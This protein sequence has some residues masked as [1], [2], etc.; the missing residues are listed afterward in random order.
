M[1]RATT[2]TARAAIEL[3]PG[4][5]VTCTF[6]NTKQGSLTVVK[7]DGGWRRRVRLQQPDAVADELQPD[8]ERRDGAAELRQSCAGR[9]RCERDCASGLGP[10]ERDLLATAVT[11]DSVLVGAGENVTCTFVNTKRGSIAVV[12]QA[13]GGEGSF[14]YSSPQLGNFRLTTSAAARSAP[15]PT[16]RRGV[17]RERDGDEWLG[18]DD[19]DLLGR[20]QPGEHQP[21]CGRDGDL[22]LRQREAGRADGGE[23]RH[24]R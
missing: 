9:L 10:G 2:A 15:S 13:T 22:H 14:S 5:D 19:G 3:D 6:E 4:A 21:G 1:R 20:E 12:K 8:D 11:P 7:T 18:P 17:Q 16:W 24:R 23:E